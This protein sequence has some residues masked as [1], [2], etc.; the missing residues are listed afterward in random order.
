[1]RKNCMI[2]PEGTRDLLFEECL[3]RRFIEDKITDV[4]K[5]RGYF[6]VIT[7]DIEFLDVF[8]LKS[9]NIPQ[10]VMYKLVDSKGRLIVM[11]PDSTMPIARLV[12]TRLKNQGLPL[13]L[14]YMQNV[15]TVSPALR[16]RNDQIMQS[17]VEIIGASSFKS[18]LEMITTATDALDACGCEQYRIEI[19]HIGIY[20]ELIKKLDVTEQMSE[21]I[22]KLIEIK[23]Y[24][25]LNDVL[26][27]L[28]QTDASNALKQLPRLFGGYEVFEKASKVLGD[29]SKI[30]EIL[31]YL[32]CL[33]QS[34]QKHSAGS[35][36]SVD[37][38]IVNRNDYYTGII[39]RG[40]ISGYGETAVSGGR[41]DKLLDEFGYD[42][43]AVGFAINIDAL[44]KAILDKNAPEVMPCDVL[45]FS[46][47]GYEIDALSYAKALASEGKYIENSMHETLEDAIEYAKQKGIATVCSVGETVKT[48]KVGGNENE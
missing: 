16:G 3:V 15:F 27:Q 26:E 32:K 30:N 9:Y 39:F 13:R 29:D 20:N 37:L 12:S 45:V 40:Y 28:P 14:F 31:D 8:N 1:M 34:L 33:Y 43:P 11:R 17:G 41:Y 4:Y 10:E 19:G 42:Q 25:M 2:T 48:Y 47:K 21:Q 7:P 46:E 24:P 5:K 18:D 6:E 44:S 22:R 36:I 38:G 35:K 23:N